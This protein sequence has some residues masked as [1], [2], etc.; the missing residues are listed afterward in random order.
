MLLSC[1]GY[2]F[3]RSDDPPGQKGFAKVGSLPA[4]MT[5]GFVHPTSSC[6]LSV[7]GSRL[8]Y[9][10]EHGRIRSTY[11]YPHCTMKWQVTDYEYLPNG[12]R[13][14]CLSIDQGIIL[15]M[16]TQS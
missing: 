3:E 13:Q 15:G 5:T 4:R 8:P 10:H 12:Q 7:M 6:I 2:P 1:A 9:L 14:K 16:C 11:E